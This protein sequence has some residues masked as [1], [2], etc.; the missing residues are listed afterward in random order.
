MIGFGQEW[1]FNSSWL[2]IGYNVTQTTDGGYALIGEINEA[3]PYLLK[4]DVNGNQIWDQSY[5]VDGWIETGQQTTDGGYI[6]MGG[7]AGPTV[8]DSYFWLTKTGSTGNIQWEQSYIN[9]A[10]CALDAGQQTSDGGYIMSGSSQATTMYDTLELL[11]IKTDANGNLQWQ[12]NIHHLDS[13]MTWSDLA[14]GRSIHQTTD[15]GYIVTAGVDASPSSAG[16]LI[17]LDAFGNQMWDQLYNNME[18]MLSLQTADGGF[19]VIG[20]VFTPTPPVFGYVVRLIK[21][22]GSGNQIWDQ[23]FALNNGFMIADIQ[24]TTDDGY[25][26]LES[27]NTLV[28]TDANG[29]QQWQQTVSTPNDN[30]GSIEQTADG[31]YILTGFR[32]QSA[33]SVDII[34]VKTDSQGSVTSTFNIPINP[35]GKLEKTVDILGKETK[36]QTNIPFIEIYDDGTVEKRIVIE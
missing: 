27:P 15:G 7:G 5:I 30:F 8:S 4:I 18:S 1:I 19:I 23:T 16:W 13:S 10:W 36:P 32:Q 6:M 35:N 24:Q 9:S 21:T 11:I 14:I 31:G 33:M 29:N 3:D 26:Y 17:K 28:K 2:D 25:I 12:Q 22:D 20:L 34:I